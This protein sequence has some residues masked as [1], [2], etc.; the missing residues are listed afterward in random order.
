M[1]ILINKKA[2]VIIGLFMLSFNTN[3]QQP[4]YEV[5]VDGVKI[6]VQPTLDEIVEI[7][8]I[9]KGGV[10]NYPA[11]KAGIE[12]IAMKMLTEG[13]TQNDDRNS[14]K[15]K[16]DKVSAT[17]YSTS[18]M[19]YSSFNL[20]CI[21]SDLSSVWNLYADAFTKPRFDEKEFARI[22][23]NQVNQIR[24]QSSNPDFAIQQLGRE[25]AFSGKAYANNPLGT[26][27]AI[28]ALT[29]ADAKDYFKMI[30]NKKQVF[31]VVVGNI[32]KPMIEKMARDVIGSLPEGN[33][34]QLSKEG[35]ATTKNTFKS[36]KKDLATN[37]VMG[38]AG[39]PQPGSKDYN[40][41]YWR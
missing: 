19:D 1:K 6:I 36:E 37:Y 4:A 38:I 11:D 40:A 2:L 24:S 20:S 13:G 25:V 32:E 31:M 17:M 5:M 23:Q 41:F 26:V 12:S 39:G 28:T 10:Q 35:Y 30:A 29:L 18:D 34:F 15:N 14:F 33:A 22:K 27:A 16:L 9:I 8:T 7:R 3:A 21:K